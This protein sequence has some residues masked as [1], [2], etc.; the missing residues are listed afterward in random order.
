MCAAEAGQHTLPGRVGYRRRVKE[1]LAQKSKKHYSSPFS[2]PALAPPRA[3]T[4]GRV[5]RDPVPLRAQLGGTAREATDTPTP[6]PPKSPQ[7]PL[8]GGTNTHT[9]HVARLL[10]PRGLASA[11][12][13]LSVSTSTNVGAAA[14]ATS[15]PIGAREDT[16]PPPAGRY[17]LTGA[18]GQIGHELVNAL[19]SILGGEAVVATDARAAPPSPLPEGV[20]YQR[21]D[22]R[23]ERAVKQGERFVSGIR[24]RG[25][26]CRGRFGEERGGGRGGGGK[27]ACEHAETTYDETT[28][29]YRPNHPRARRHPLRG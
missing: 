20:R 24:Q 1:R 22:V 29:N 14:A 15:G 8:E 7:L 5:P 25:C 3:R 11:S 23:D 16:P 4:R 2:S 26:R 27:A 18:C 21:L 12:G 10:A 13:R 28:R 17:L 9:M 19:S 6:P